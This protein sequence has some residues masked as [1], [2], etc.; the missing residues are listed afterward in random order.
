MHLRWRNR[1]KF[2]QQHPRTPMDH[3]SLSGQ[4]RGIPGQRCDR[5]DGTERESETFQASCR[6]AARLENRDLPDTVAANLNTAAE[7]ISQ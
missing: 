5:G 3:R 6:I 1:Q 7:F 4:N 2:K